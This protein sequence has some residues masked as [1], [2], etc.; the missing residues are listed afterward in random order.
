MGFE[1]SNREITRNDYENIHR[2]WKNVENFALMAST[3]H[4]HSNTHDVQKIVTSVCSLAYR[5]GLRLSEFF[6]DFDPLKH[7]E[8]PSSALNCILTQLNLSLDPKDRELLLA[9]YPSG[10]LKRFHYR[11]FL[12]DCEVATDTFQPVVHHPQVVNR[13]LGGVKAE[14]AQDM[15]AQKVHELHPQVLRSLQAQVYERRVDFRAFCQDFDHLRKGFVLSHK[16]RSILSL[17]NFHMTEDEIQVLTHYYARGDD[18]MNYVRL[19]D[20]VE[21][22]LFCGPLEANPTGKPPPP[23]DLFA[24][25]EGKKPTLSDSE[26]QVITEA[27]D[28]IKRRV[29]HRGISLLPQLRSY[30]K[31]NRLVITDNQFRRAMVTL[32][33]EIQESDLNVLMKKYCING[34]L[35]RFAYRDFCSS[36]DS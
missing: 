28:R 22:D 29:K 25:K 15:S 20:D 1:S 32:G 10:D 4:V 23:F 5:R 7:G 14:R 27:E 30:D 9:A 31:Y 11:N 24:A 17:L 13:A 35:S 21:K 8:C 6:R 18:S 36:I 19:C 26:S 2:D 34:S 12:K 3:N 16:L 33:F